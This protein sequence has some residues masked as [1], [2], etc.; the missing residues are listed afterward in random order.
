MKRD[1]NTVNTLVQLNIVWDESR[2][3]QLVTKNIA[4]YTFS[5]LSSEYSDY[6]KST[7]W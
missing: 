7:A 1:N 6:G 3:Q 4:S 2:E 5:N